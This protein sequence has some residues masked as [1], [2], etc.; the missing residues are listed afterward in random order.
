[1]LYVS[2]NMSPSLVH[3]IQMERG[4]SKRTF[5][6][7]LDKIWSRLRGWRSKHSSLPGR[8]TLAKSVIFFL[9]VYSM[10]SL[11]MP[12]GVCDDIDKHTRDFIWGGSVENHRLHLVS[13]ENI[14]KSKEVGGPW[15]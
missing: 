1:M 8:V 3:Q 4:V 5:R 10:A 14:Y 9:P 2:P 6:P 12:A 11:A 13:G 7:L 15:D